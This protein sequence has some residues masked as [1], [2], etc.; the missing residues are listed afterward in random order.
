[1]KIAIDAGHGLHTAGKRCMQ[2]IDPNQTRE[3]TLNSRIA[4]QVCDLL[5]TAGH[6]TLR[7]DDPTGAVDVPLST[8]STTANQW[9]ADLCVSIHHDSGVGGTASG[10]MTVFVYSGGASDT[11]KRL[12]KEVY[13]AAIAQTNLAGNRSEP[14]RSANFHMVR[15]P[16]MPAILMECGFMDSTTDVPIILSQ[17]FALQCAQGI[18]QGI[19]A[20]AGGTIGAQPTPTAAATTTPAGDCPAWAEQACAWAVAQGYF[21][22]DGSGNFDWNKTLTRAELAQV[23]F[24]GK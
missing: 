5:A 8:R 17:A 18:A 14:L 1:M 11:S 19:C 4:T 9:G 2:A 21:A 3:W 13:T 16:K 7:L 20:V 23:L 6:Q 22:G 10:G 24:N 15:A 12:Q